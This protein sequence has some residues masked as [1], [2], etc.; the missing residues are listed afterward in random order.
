MKKRFVIFLLTLISF[1]FLHAEEGGWNNSFD[2]ENI[3]TYIG[4]SN[5]KIIVAAV[6]KEDTEVVNA[7]K[8]LE[9]SFKKSGKTSLVM[10][11]AALGDISM[12][13]DQA[14]VKKASSFPVTTIVILRIFSN[15]AV[16]TFYNK[17]G[18]S[19]AAFSVIKGVKV[20]ASQPMGV[21]EPKAEV[22]TETKMEQPPSAS[23]ITTVND[24]YEK[25]YITFY[26]FSHNPTLGR[27]GMGV[28]NVT[29]SGT[30]NTNMTFQSLNTIYLEWDE[31]YTKIG[32]NELAATYKR[33]KTIKYIL[34]T[35]GLILA[36]GSPM[37]MLY[38][39]DGDSNTGYIVAGVG[40]AVGFTAWLSGMY[41]DP[42]PVTAS[43]AREMT[44]E[45]NKRR[46]AG[47]SLSKNGT[48]IEKEDS[49]KVSMSPY[50]GYNS[51]GIALNIRF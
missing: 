19:V 13:D 5:E 17:K 35:G 39:L 21:L 50:F 46:K 36:L 6:G 48:D 24:D 26:N 11:D 33:D 18:E 42:H 25:N 43:E 30:A 12:L 1:A 49:F 15:S 14:I 32:G 27:Q 29:T 34:S 47:L 10:N 28:A 51:G 16:V 38:D 9:E 7:A 41:Y 37:F 20:T 8:I 4:D 23:S 44:D 22:S 31:F 45:Y 2:P 40:T 3:K